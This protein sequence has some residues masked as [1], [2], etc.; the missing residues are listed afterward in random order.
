VTTFHFDCCLKEFIDSYIHGLEVG[1]RWY[2]IMF[3]TLAHKELV[4][5]LIRELQRQLLS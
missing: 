1:V 3:A 2:L 5:N 4:A